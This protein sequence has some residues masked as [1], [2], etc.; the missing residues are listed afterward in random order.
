[1]QRFWVIL[2]L[3][4][5]VSGVVA[6]WWFK[7]PQEALPELLPCAD[8]VNGCGNAEVS[9]QSDQMPKVMQVF[10]LRL[11][12]QD[13]QSVRARFDMR[14]MQMGLNQYRFL[15]QQNGD[16]LAKVTLPVCVSGSS[17]WVMNIEMDTGAGKRRYQLPFTAGD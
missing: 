3:L 7:Q 2:L 11:K 17:D 16:W 4:F 8:L 6:W 9:V 1:M 12:A 14:E 10:E 15:R 5:G 13:A